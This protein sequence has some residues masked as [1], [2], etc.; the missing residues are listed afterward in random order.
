MNSI[1]FEYSVP[2]YVLSKIMGKVSK[3]FY[4]NSRLSCVR[5]RRVEVPKL[6][7]DEWVKVRVKYGGIC[8][9][10]LNLILLKDSPTTSPFVSFPFT[11]G[12]EVVGTIEE[13][14]SKVENVNVGDRVV[15]DPILSC[16]TRGIADPCPNC[17]RGD[18]N[19]CHFMT[20]GVISPGLLIG[21]CRDT[22]GSWGA[23]LVAHKSQVLKLPDN[24]N[25]LNGVLVEPFSCA[26]HAV[27]R[28]PPKKDDTVL[29]IGAGT[30]G[31]CVVAAI[32]ALEFPCRI[33]VLAKHDFQAQ[34]ASHYGADEIIYFT[35]NKN[36]IYETAKS[37]QASVLDPLFGDPVVQGGADLIFECVGNKQ[38][39]NDALRFVKN[40]GKAVLLG[41]AGIID[42]VDWTTVWLNELDVKGS[43]AYSTEEYQGKKMRTLQIAIEL[44]HN[45]KVDLSPLVTHRFPLENYRHALQTVINKGKGSTMKVVLEP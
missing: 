3:S 42:G 4:W 45:E 37:L 21:A 36:Y 24:V 39:I 23:Y 35:K 2:R 15:I 30:I 16:I 32:K 20:E 14:G 17:R 38:S 33:V 12:H 10:D 25:D 5:L 44:M 1:Q 34:L 22:G 43:F 26:L 6:P 18:Y 27:L 31:I 40:G 28:N 11:I 7:N 8:G 13:V 19:L 29:V 9:S 41:L